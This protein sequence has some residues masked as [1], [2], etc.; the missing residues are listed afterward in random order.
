MSIP[1]VRKIGLAQGC[2]KEHPHRAIREGSKVIDIGGICRYYDLLRSAVSPAELF[3]LNIER[4]SVRGCQS[5]VANALQLPFCDEIWDAAI[6]F[7]LVEHLIEPAGLLSE[8][9][10]VLRSVG[11]FVVST[12]NLADVFSRIIFLFGY[13]PF[14]YDPSAYKWISFQ[15]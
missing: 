10:Q 3:L 15:G 12:P 5:I 1:L 8:V 6:S 4:D 9:S 7:E 2:L 14:N 13:N 11:V